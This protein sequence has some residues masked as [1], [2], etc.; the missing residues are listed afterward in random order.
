MAIRED[1]ISP[2]RYARIG[3][4]LYLIIIVA[5]LFGEIFVRGN[6]IVSGDAAATADRILASQTLWRAGIAAD[7]VMHLCDV[8]LMMILYVLLKPVS[9]NLALLAMLFTL[10]QSSVLVANKLSLLDALFLLGNGSYLNGADP[11]QLQAIAYMFLKS[12]AYGFGVGLI[13]F[14]FECLIVGYLIVKSGYFPR[15]IGYAMQ[16]AGVCYL[17]NSFSLLLAP[18]FAGMIFPLILVPSF[19]GEL[20]L[21][22]WMLIKGVDVAKWQQRVDQ[23]QT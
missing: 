11:R 10:V 14:A 23:R 15:L 4:V 13:F 17:I 5:G 22:L 21:C 8:G 20:S 3:G 18:D 6:L 19:L 16:L 7:I 2:Q 1:P 9:K 12:H